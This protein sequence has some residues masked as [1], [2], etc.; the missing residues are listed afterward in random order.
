[1]NKDDN[2]QIVQT[3]AFSSSKSQLRLTDLEKLEV[4]QIQASPRKAGQANHEGVHYSRELILRL[5]HW[6]KDS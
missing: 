4:E 5:I 3:V 2:I 6:F 1:V